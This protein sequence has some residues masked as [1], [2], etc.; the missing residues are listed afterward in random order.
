MRTSYENK[1]AM[2]F[3]GSQYIAH[4]RGCSPWLNALELL[5]AVSL[6]NNSKA[7][8]RISPFHPSARAV[9]IK[10]H[11][12]SLAHSASLERIIYYRSLFFNKGNVLAH[13]EFE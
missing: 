4:R 12:K 1:L 10:N 6:E 5:E 11:S 7:R 9:S 2:T 8:S 3:A 13:S